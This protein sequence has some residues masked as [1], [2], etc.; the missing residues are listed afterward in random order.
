MLVAPIY[1]VIT[2]VHVIMDLAETEHI[3]MVFISPILLP[4]S[5]FCPDSSYYK[6]FQLHQHCIYGIHAR[7]C[8]VCKLSRN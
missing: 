1:M 8:H 2:A 5:R 6:L 7:A 4:Y 3:A